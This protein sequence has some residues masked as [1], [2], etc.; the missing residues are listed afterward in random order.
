MKHSFYLLS[1]AGLL[2][3]NG[4][5]Q[6]RSINFEHGTFKELK[7]KALKEHKLIF[8]DAY[9]TWCGPCKYLAKYVFTNDTVADN[10]NGN[11]INAKF[12]MEKGEGL[13][14][15]KQYEV[16]CYPT[17]LFIDGN[18]NLVHKTAGAGDAKGMVELAKTAKDNTHNYLFYK[19]NYTAKKK[20]PAFL[21]EYIEV[22]INT[23]SMPTHAIE[24]YFS[25]QKESDLSNEQNWNMIN[26]YTSNIE[27]RE[28]K[29]LLSHK[30]DFEKLYTAKAVDEKITNVSLEMLSDVIYEETF[31]KVKYEE[32]KQSVLKLNLSNSK[33]ILFKAD[34][35]LAKKNKD[36]KMFAA[37][38]MENVDTYYSNDNNELNNIAWEFYE[39]V[40]D[41]A[42]LVK[43]EAWAKQSVTLEPSYASLDTYASLLYKLGKK[44][45]ALAAA[46]KAIEYAKK[47]NYSPGDYQSTT[48]LLVKIKEMK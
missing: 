40:F 33:L 28:F 45:L 18:G 22:M 10:Y 41:V 11:F 27:S 6:N 16:S 1:L 44:D 46:T 17:L 23:C 31:N 39:N 30:A 12:D 9:T 25:L 13:E 21:S 38:A 43:A 2:T 5:A 35:A 15:A 48:D 14:L 42:P 29:Y 32:A 8:M 19:T 24:Q 37:L 26:Q 20:D 34:L 3:L 7:E 47:D 4:T 36:W